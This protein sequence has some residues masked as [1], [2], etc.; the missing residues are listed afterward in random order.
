[1]KDNFLCVVLLINPQRQTQ[2]Q[3]NGPIPS[4]TS[5]TLELIFLRTQFKWVF[6]NVISWNLFWFIVWAASA[7][8]EAWNC[9]KRNNGRGVEQAKT[10]WRINWTAITAEFP[11]RQTGRNLKRVKS[12]GPSMAFA[13][14]HSMRFC[15]AAVK[16][17]F[18]ARLSGC[19][20]GIFSK[21]HKR[22]QRTHMH[23]SRTRGTKAVMDA[24]LAFK[25]H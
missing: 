8:D 13:P 16:I 21:G 4:G 20:P 5:K 12:Q 19:S 25:W 22:K 15:L 3:L 24:A 17:Q 18:P 14:D 6:T 2:C 9:P 7:D 23:Q 11:W 1:L 10:L